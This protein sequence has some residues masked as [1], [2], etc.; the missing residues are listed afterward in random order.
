MSAEARNDVELK[1]TEVFAAAAK[2]EFAAYL[3]FKKQ[4]HGSSQ[5]SVTKNPFELGADKRSRG[6]K[7]MKRL[8][9]DFVEALARGHRPPPQPTLFDKTQ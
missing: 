5:L 7:K 3:D 4:S 6:F 2:Y 9:Q 8:Q 1:I